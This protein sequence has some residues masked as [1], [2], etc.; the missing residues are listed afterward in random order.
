M[1]IHTTPHT[2]A[3][4]PAR[5]PW[6]ERRHITTGDAY[7]AGRFGGGGRAN[8]GARRQRLLGLLGGARHLQEFTPSREK[9]FHS[10]PPHAL[11]HNTNR[12]QRPIAASFQNTDKV[13]RVESDVCTDFVR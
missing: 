1:Q 11:A 10:E 5:G 4:V 9:C 12:T 13:L 8:G 7:L 6:T 2:G 3:V